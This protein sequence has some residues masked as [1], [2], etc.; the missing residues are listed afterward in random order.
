M[1]RRNTATMTPLRHQNLKKYRMKIQPLLQ[2][3]V[4]SSCTWTR[5]ASLRTPRPSS[6]SVGTYQPIQKSKTLTKITP[7]SRLHT[8]C[9]EQGRVD[10]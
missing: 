3:S 10:I 6:K 5:P 4:N 1:F 2:S 9:F 8:Y 7:R